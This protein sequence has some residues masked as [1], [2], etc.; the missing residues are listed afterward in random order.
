MLNRFFSNRSAFT[1]N[2]VTLVS[3][4]ALAQAVNFGFNIVL[5]RLYAP[6]DFG[7]LSVFLSLVS[8]IIVVSAGKYDVALV[9]THSDEDAKGLTTLGMLIT[10]AVAAMVLLLVWIIYAAPIR[11]YSDNPVHNWF[12][13]IPASVIFLSIFQVLWMWNVRAKRFKNISFIRPLEAFV[14]NG[15]CIL[16]KAY[17][18]FGLILGALA[19]QMVSMFVITS[20]SLKKDGPGLFVSPIKKL[21]ELGFR[22]I[23][24]PKINIL[25]GFAETL[26]MGII[27]LVASGYF[28]AADVGFYAQCMRVLQAPARLIT[29]PLAHVFFSEASQHFREGKDIYPLVKRVAYQAG[30]WLLPIPVILIIAGPLLFKVVFGEQWTE[31]GVYAAI[32]SPWIFLDMIRG[33]IVQVAS[34]MGKQKR[35]LVITLISNAIL[36]LSLIFGIGF[37]LRFGTVLIVVSTTQSIMCLY[38]ISVIFKMSRIVNI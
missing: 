24:F 2:I 22:Y 16:L 32:L 3:A 36:L 1:K 27:V 7:V 37:G 18:D 17:K 12:Y 23:E 21:S 30:L 9:A 11:F 25:Q 13:L 19:G 8:F 20:V 33:P 14:N 5:A 6:A 4:T 29:L 31:A 10:I 35:I 26:Q 15:L 38:L 34:I 28:P